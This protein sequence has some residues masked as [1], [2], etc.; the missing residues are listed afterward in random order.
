M[1][2]EKGKTTVIPCEPFPGRVYDVT[3]DRFIDA[4][5]TGYQIA[6]RNIGELQGLGTPL[7]CGEGQPRHEIIVIPAYVA[8]GAAQ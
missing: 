2:C 5:I 1:S 4:M 3:N 8:N 6:I 7:S